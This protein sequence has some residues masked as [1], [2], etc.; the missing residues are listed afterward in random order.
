[1]YA[2]EIIWKRADTVKG[3]F[4]QG[5]KIWGANTDTILFYRKSFSNTFNPSYTEYTEEYLKKYYRFMEPDTNRRY[6]LVSMM[7]PG[8]AA[9]GNPRYEVMGVTRYWRYSKQK[10]QELIDAGMVVQTS[11]GAV[12]LRKLYLDDGKGVAI[13]SLWDDI[14]AMGA[15]AGE[16]L[17]YP[18]QKPLTLLERI[19]K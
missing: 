19:I 15:T 7:G 16:R 8:G 6:R 3:N 14:P 18:T 4:G 2:N 10:M 13:Q 1:M 9:K 11:P 12:P 5:S 17:G